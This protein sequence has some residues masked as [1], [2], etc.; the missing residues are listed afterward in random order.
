MSSVFAFMVAAAPHA[1]RR[2]RKAP[3]VI[4][5]AARS[6]HEIRDACRAGR[7]SPQAV[8]QAFVE[9]AARAN[10][11]LGAFIAPITAALPAGAAEADA[12]G[13]P[14]CGVPLA[15]KD[16]IA[17][18]GQPWRAGLVDAA[19]VDA[20]EDAAVVAR[21][22]AA[23]GVILGRTAMD[24][25]G[26]GAAGVNPHHGP[27][28]NPAA[29]GFVAGGSSAGSA[30][31]VA[32][33]CAPVALGTDTMGSVRIP[34]AF[35]GVVGFKPTRGLLPMLGV[36]PLAPSLDEIGVMARTVADARLVLAVLRGAP[37]DVAAD[38]VRPPQA[39]LEGLVLGRLPAEAAARLEEPVGAAFAAACAR[40]TAAGGRIVDL[41]APAGFCARLRKEVFLVVEVEGARAYGELLD[42]PLLGATLRRLLAFGRD[43]PP[44]RHA[45]AVAVLA[46]ATR[47]I[48]RWLD[49][50]DMLITPTTPTRA[51]ARGAEPPSGLADFTTLANVAG[52]P[53]ISIPAGTA[54]RPIG[55]QLIGAAGADARVLDAADVLQRLAAWS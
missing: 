6:A 52:L 12:C 39:G 8:A 44:E 37:A 1:Q 30:A 51:F 15:V 55:V 26:L 21:W 10:G 19:A 23:G 22:R 25:A 34:A 11:R 36:R 33:G 32:A 9:A 35:C 49:G 31:A 14:A 40:V 43:L 4:D 48:R 20:A 29:P 47:E 17:V 18:A 2:A 45:E 3:A 54:E 46:E 7:T 13:L 16:N 38:R 42:G 50:V 41:D 27:V 5:P 24:E 28:E 53:A